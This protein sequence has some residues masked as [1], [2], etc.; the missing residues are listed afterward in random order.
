MSDQ[1]NILNNVEQKNPYIQNISSI[2]SQQVTQHQE[3]PYKVSYV[4][5]IMNGQNQPKE[6]RLSHQSNA[7]QGKVIRK[8]VIY[9]NYY[10]PENSGIQEGD[11]KELSQR[12]KSD[13]Y[14]FEKDSKQVL[15]SEHE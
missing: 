4:K 11:K 7:P 1:K 14:G 12:Q 10:T 9:Q 8:S 2:S 6:V 15:F 3:S 13:E 5:R